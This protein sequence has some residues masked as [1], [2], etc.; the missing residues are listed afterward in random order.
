[1][2]KGNFTPKDNPYFSKS[3]EKG[4]RI[5][6]LFNEHKTVSTQTEIAR[7]MNLNMTSTYRFINTLVCLG[8]LKKDESSKKLRL[9]MRALVQAS[10]H[11]RAMDFH[12]AI[13]S[14]VDEV[15]EKHNITVDVA[16]VVED[17]LS[18]VYRREAADT[19]IYRLPSLSRAWHCT[20][21]GKAYLAFLP[22]SDRRAIVNSLNLEPRTGK[23]IVSRKRLWE[24]ISKTRQR[25][26]AVCDEEFIP[27]LITLGVPLINSENGQT[28]GAISFDFST[29]Q[30]NVNRMTEQ[31]ADLIIKLGQNISDIITVS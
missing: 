3:L 12:A 24:E 19:L 21:L 13:K 30:Q 11:L 6:A 17:A 31:Y 16:L 7:A 14:L 22:E 27:G 8:Y 15:Y 20:S 26:Y 28:I 29:I 2:A 9:G 25:G 18:I 4:L 10:T 5:L 23:T 1:M